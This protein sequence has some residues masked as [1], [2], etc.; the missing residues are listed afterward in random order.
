MSE[1]ENAQRLRRGFAAFAERDLG[2]LHELFAD[3]VSWTIPGRNALAGTYVGLAAV[4]GMLGTAVELT[5]GT[6][7][8][9][10]TFVLADDAH[11]A[12]AYRATGRRGGERL[13]IDQLLLCRF[14]A[15]RIVEVQALPADQARF[16]AFWALAL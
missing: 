4:L 2:A 10:L 13:D 8:T 11:A 3:A 15:G 16:D 1:H 9:E 5:D 7:G 12:A 6:Y 14:A